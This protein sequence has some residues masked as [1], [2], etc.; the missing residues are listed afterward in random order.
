[1]PLSFSNV[2]GKNFHSRDEVKIHI[3]HLIQ[4]QK[5]WCGYIGDVTGKISVSLNKTIVILL[6]KITILYLPQV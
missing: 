1:M 5:S 3:G 6:D 2:P 4:Y